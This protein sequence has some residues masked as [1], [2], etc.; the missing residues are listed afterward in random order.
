MLAIAEEMA[1]CLEKRAATTQ[2][3]RHAAKRPHIA[4]QAPLQIEND[5]GRAVGARGDES[6]LRRVG[7]GDAAEVDEAK[8]VE[9]RL[10]ILGVEGGRQSYGDRGA[11]DG[12]TVV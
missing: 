3:V 2:F 7:G 1:V 4:R 8:M 10:K 12:T 6:S 5:L 9:I 11:V